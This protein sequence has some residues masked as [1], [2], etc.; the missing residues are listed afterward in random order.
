MYKLVPPKYKFK[1]KVH[2][3]QASGNLAYQILYNGA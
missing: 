1:A 3:S 2:K